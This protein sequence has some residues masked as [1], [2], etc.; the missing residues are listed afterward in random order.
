MGTLQYM[1]GEVQY[2]GRITDKIDRRLFMAYTEAW[3]SA[4]TLASTFSFSPDRPINTSSGTFAYK[5]PNFVEIS[6]YMSY[7]NTF[8]EVDSPEVLGLHPNADLTFRF[9]EVHQLLDTIVETQPKQS[10]GESG[11][12]TREELVYKKCEE[13]KE[14][15][16]IDY[17]E[18][19]YEERIIALGGFQ[20]P[21]NIFLYQEVQRLQAAIDKVR[22]T[23]G[24][25]MQGIKGEIVVTGDILD[26]INAINDARVPKSWL[27]N[28]AGDEVSWI[29]PTLGAWYA[30][31]I[32]RDTQYR[33][34][35]SNGRPHSYWL[36]GFFNPQGYLTAVQQEITRAH[37]NENWA[38]DSVVVHAEMT[39]I[40]NPDN[41]KSTPKEGLYVHGLFMDGAAWRTHDGT[42][43]ESEPKKLF[44]PMPIM[45]VTAVT[46]ASKKALT[47]GGNYGPFGA[48]DCPVYKYPIR[49]D[50]YFIFTVMLATQDHKP[51]H[52]TLRGVALLCA[53]A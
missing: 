14:T 35:L 11:G 19:E 22:S 51:L 36:T 20:V 47:S 41:I 16:P 12:K 27:Y 34:W 10:S 4:N 21:L 1:A 45:L 8:P 29:S 32:A 48:Y 38:L 43:Q 13:L 39:E 40:M 18:D 6:E 3:L 42:L 17:V 5:I 9:K 24:L 28:P 23:L 26:S 7:I 31:L 25:V 2:G 49:S 44:S 15:V 46:K 53:T 50:K 52:W 33:S 37:K 30:S